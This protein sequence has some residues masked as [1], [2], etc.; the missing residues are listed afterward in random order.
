MIIKLNSYEDYC[1]V[2]DFMESNEITY[3][4]VPRVVELPM[5]IDLEKL[6]DAVDSDNDAAGQGLTS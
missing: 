1:K 2:V 6:T 4:D 5:M 3:A